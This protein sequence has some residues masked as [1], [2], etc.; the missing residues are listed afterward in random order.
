VKTGNEEKLRASEVG[1]CSCV[2]PDNLNSVSGTQLVKRKQ[3]KTKKQKTP[4]N[5]SLNSKYVLH[6]TH[7]HTHTYTH[8]HTH[9]EIETETDRD[10]DRETEDR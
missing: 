9:I 8:T 2:K 5:C 7:T 1:D 6:G 3:N 4:P 10:R